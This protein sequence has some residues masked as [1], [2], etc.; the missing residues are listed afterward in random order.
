MNWRS[1]LWSSIPE[2]EQSIV[3]IKFRELIDDISL[4]SESLYVVLFSKSFSDVVVSV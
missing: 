4:H 2:G 3:G 1:H